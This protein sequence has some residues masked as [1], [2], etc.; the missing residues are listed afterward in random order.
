MKK[1]CNYSLFIGVL[2]FLIYEKCFFVLFSLNDIFLLSFKGNETLYIIGLILTIILNNT[3]IVS[4][5]KSFAKLETYNLYI[6]K[7]LVILILVVIMF[8]W[9]N[10]YLGYLGKSE[11]EQELQNIFFKYYDYKNTIYFINTTILIILYGYNVLKANI[12]NGR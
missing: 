9:T 1:K 2:L 8:L 5:H 4:L 12:D 6:V 11:V 7:L 3:V 10:Y